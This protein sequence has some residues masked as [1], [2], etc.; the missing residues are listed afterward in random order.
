MKTILYIRMSESVVMLNL[1]I[2]RTGSDSMN[3][4]TKEKE[5]LLKKKLETHSTLINTEEI[6]VILLVIHY[7]LPIQFNY[8]L[9]Q[10]PELQYNSTRSNTEVINFFLE[11][12]NN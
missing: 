5:N 3:Y 4:R 8:A 11:R 12:H 10:F 2:L 6:T 7:I 9:V 1:L